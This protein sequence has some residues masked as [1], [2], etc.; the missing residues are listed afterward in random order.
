[1]LRDSVV[2]KYDVRGGNSL[3]DQSIDISAALVKHKYGKTKRY[4]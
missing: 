4:H 2:P 3:A 1:M